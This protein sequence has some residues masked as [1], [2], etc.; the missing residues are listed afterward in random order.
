MLTS[1]SSVKIANIFWTNWGNS[2]KFSGKMWLLI[3]LKA[4]KKTQGFTLSVEDTVLEKQQ[5]ERVQVD[6]IQSFSD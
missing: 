1:T 4:T 2:M 5:R 6:R 3:I